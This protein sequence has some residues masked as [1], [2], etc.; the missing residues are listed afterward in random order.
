MHT[1]WR[2]IAH[3]LDAVHTFQFRYFSFL[4]VNDKLTLCLQDI[5]AMVA[6]GAITITIIFLSGSD[7]E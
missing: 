5:V 4:L 2:D 7:Y 3:F 6:F 1:S